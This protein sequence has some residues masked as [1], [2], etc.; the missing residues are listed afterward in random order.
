MIAVIIIHRIIS[1]IQ[2]LTK[3]S[4]KSISEGTKLFETLRNSPF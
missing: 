1:D 4:R 3:D 2:R